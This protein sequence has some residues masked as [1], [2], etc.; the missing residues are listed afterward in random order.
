MKTKIFDIIRRLIFVPLV[1]LCV[2]FSIIFTVSYLLIGVP[3]Y[4]ILTG[5]TPPDYYL[6]DYK[7]KW[8]TYVTKVLPNDEGKY[9]I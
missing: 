9:I 4:W 5:D 2:I 7:E 6:E 3:L 8:F 1:I